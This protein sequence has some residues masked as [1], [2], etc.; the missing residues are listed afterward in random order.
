MKKHEVARAIVDRMD[1]LTLAQVEDCIDTFF[2]VLA[3]A[4]AEGESYNQKNFGTFKRIDRAPRKGR[5]PQTRE[6]VDIPGSKALKVV[7][8]NALKEKL[9]H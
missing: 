7:V 3:D 2:D 1:G 9:N 6:I 4:L 5:N 8:S